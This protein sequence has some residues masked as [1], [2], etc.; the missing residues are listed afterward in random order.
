MIQKTKNTNG[1]KTL[2][3]VEN[4]RT[5]ISKFLPKDI[6]WGGTLSYDKLSK[7][8]GKNQRYLRTLKNRITNET[9]PS[10][11]PNFTFS[12]ADLDGFIIKL[13]ENFGEDKIKHCNQLISAYKEEVDVFDYTNQQWQIHNPHLRFDAFK[14]LDKKKDGYYFGLLLADGTSDNRKNIGLFLEKTDIKVIERL[15]KDLRIS[16]QIEHEIDKRKKKKNSEFPE[17]YGVRVGCKPMMEN[18]KKL[19]Y[20]HFKSGEALEEGFFTNLREDI[21]YSVLLGFYDGD[22]EKGTSKIFSTN[23]K[24][25]EQIKK[26][27]NI[28]S[29][30]RI[31][32]KSGEHFV[33]YKNCRTKT[34][35]Y[36]AL[37]SEIFNK[38]ME[39]YKFSMERKRKYYPLG[40]SRFVYESLREKIKTKEN[41]ERLILNGPTYKL[42]EVFNVNFQTFKK[43]FKEWKVDPLPISFWKRQDNKGWKNDFD[44]KMK[45]FLDNLN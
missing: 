38:M 6:L 7:Y 18:L 32:S 27:F 39:I 26:E 40:P 16:N 21:R 9:Y 33:F 2:S 10:Y 42:T 29:D 24:F 44:E 5:E 23:K 36:L 3:L 1:L 8:L 17:R 11:N 13:S 4:L 14:K 31:S 20:F 28:A 37:G 35:Y 22:G 15:K 19:G 43:L 30:L 25:L 41:L 12:R 45:Q 34:K